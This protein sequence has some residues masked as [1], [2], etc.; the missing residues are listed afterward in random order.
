MS[1]L[2]INQENKDAQT[3]QTSND[4]GSETQIPPST[5]GSVGDQVGGAPAKGSSTG[6]PTQFGSSAS[7]LG[8]YLSANAPQI[9]GQADTLAGNLNTQYSNLNQGITNAANQFQQGVQGGYAANNPDAVNQA[10]ADPTKF[11]SDPSNVKAF[12]GQYNNQYTGPTSFEGM[13]GYN[14]IQNQ[15]GQA[16]TQAGLIG[17]GNAGLTS[18]LSGQAKGNPTQASNTLDSLMLQGN[19]E[20][21]K[22][23]NDAAAPFANLTGQ[24]NTATQGADQSVVDAQKAATDSQAYARGQFDPFAQQFGNSLNTQLAGVNTN[25]D[26]YN[27]ATTKNQSAAQQYQAQLLQAQQDANARVKFGTDNLGTKAEGVAQNARIQAMYTP[28]LQASLA[29]LPQYLSGQP[30]TQPGTLANTAT[31]GQY[32]EDA[33]LSQLLGQGYTPQL[34]QADIGQAGSYSV[35][36][37]P[38]TVTDPSGQIQYAN[39]ISNLYGYQDLGNSNTPGGWENATNS[40]VAQSMLNIGPNQG[41]NMDANRKAA[42]QRLVANQYAGR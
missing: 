20:A 8:D 21:T 29:G 15:V 14:D 24:L 3:G 9:Q 39:D 33:A 7:K 10:M 16:V 12:Q 31:A 40:Q 11:A 30:I 38:S 2:P 19:P 36:G 17:S 5:G 22:K 1:F 13:G 37:M 34:N 18:Y 35:P 27:A 32:G 41:V 23:I 25:R 4:P 42:L 28:S 6:S 26:A